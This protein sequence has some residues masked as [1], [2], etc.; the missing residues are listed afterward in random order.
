MSVL[1]VPNG[2]AGVRAHRFAWLLLSALASVAGYWLGAP[3]W[4]S[5][6]VFAVSAFPVV[7]GMFLHGS[8][9]P[10]YA[11]DIETMLW[12][13]LATAACAVNGG[14]GSPAIILYAV[15]IVMAAVRGDAKQIIE[16]GVFVLI[17]YAFAAIASQ[18][19]LDFLDGDLQLLAGVLSIGGLALAAW[20]ATGAR[21]LDREAAPRSQEDAAI[22]SAG[23]AE[24]RQLTQ[25]IQQLQTRAELL[26][27]ELNEARRALLARTQFFAQTSH[28]LRNPLTAIVG[29]A[30][31][32]K[33][34]VFGPL[35][36]RYQEYA[37]LIHE[38]GQTL[39][40][41][42]DD[43]INMSRIEAGRYEISPE[44]ISLSDEAADAARFMGE[45]AKRKG[46][47]LI[48]SGKRSVE[49]Y[50][51][52]K[53]VK[54]IALNLI[55]NAIKFTPEGGKIEVQALS[56][57]NGALLAVSDTGAGISAEELRRLSR[58]FEQGEAGRKQHGSGLGLSVVRALAELHQGRLEIESREGGGAT[59]AVYFPSEPDA[60]P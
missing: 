12:I 13:A 1:E 37:E 46:V 24:F 19:S 5:A 42:I 59:V 7:I 22:L 35:P 39:G 30:E 55:S 27:L 40:M 4:L 41:L 48:Y 56:G 34:A 47:Q 3:A 28:E 60:R 52:P 21:R 11:L 53:A 43:V 57:A 14:L 9:A 50:A 31:M 45:A 16:A 25:R 51:D 44:P 54:Q 23:Q 15:P 2:V 33:T 26:E 29:F 18:A 38:G 8:L 17:G 6:G 20:L 32:M 49:A 10:E 36:E 58:A